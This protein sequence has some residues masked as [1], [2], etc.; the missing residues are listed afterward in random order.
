M[1]DRFRIDHAYLVEPS[2]NRL[3]GPSGIT[4]LE[5]KVMLVLVCLAERAGQLVPKDRLLRAAWADTAVTDDV[6]TRAISELRR[7]FDDDPKQPRV[8]ETIPKAGYRLIAPIMPLAADATTT[9]AGPVTPTTSDRDTAIAEVLPRVQG[10]AAHRRRRRCADP[11]HRL[12]GVVGA[13][14][15]PQRD[16]AASAGRTAHHSAR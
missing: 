9:L 12:C 7:L 6:L 11:R 15:A 3:T 5:P 1:H 16:A 13:L 14:S 2:L 4:R 10:R 8:I